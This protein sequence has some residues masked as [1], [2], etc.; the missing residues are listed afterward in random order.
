MVGT[1][2]RGGASVRSNPRLGSHTLAGW[3]TG[4]LLWLAVGIGTLL[5][6]AQYLANPSLTADESFLVL[7]IEHSRSPICSAS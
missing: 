3:S 2:A 1:P 5:R 7:N 4:R 6:L